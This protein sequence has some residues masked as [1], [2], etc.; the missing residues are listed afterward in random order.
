VEIAVVDDCSTDAA[1]LAILG[2]L[3][4]SGVN[5][6]RHE[7]NQGLAAARNS[8]LA[9][10]GAP[11]VFPLDADDLAMPGSITEMAAVLDARPEAAACYGDYLEFGEYELVRRVPRRLDPY[12]LAFRNEYPVTALHR[13]SVLTEVGGW[14]DHRPIAGYE[15]W[16]LWLK[17]TERGY[18]GAYAGDGIVTFRK[19]G[20]EGSMLAALRGHHRELYRSLKSLHPAIYGSLP[21][22]RRASDL[23]PVAKLLYPVVFGGRPRSRYERAVKFW[24]YRQ[25]TRLR[26]GSHS[27]GSGPTGPA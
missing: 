11:Y 12:R 21:Q 15:D 5:V 19:R 2:E 20:R 14:R 22:L 9:A 27:M 1:T 25:A 4:G 24:V 10:T 8:G 13:R 17:L 23:G 18:R 6:V 26:S 16:D 3:A 7:T